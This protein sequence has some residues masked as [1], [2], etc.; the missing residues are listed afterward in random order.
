MIKTNLIILL[1]TIIFTLIL[2]K[3]NI[4]NFKIIEEEN[5]AIMKSEEIENF[6]YEVLPRFVLLTF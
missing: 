3:Y 1:I 5:E 6:L 2:K 4:E